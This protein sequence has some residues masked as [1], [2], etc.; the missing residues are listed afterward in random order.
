[1]N[2]QFE[3]TPKQTDFIT[4]TSKF[5][6]FSG[7]YGAGKTIAGCMRGLL[8]SQEPGNFGL[9][10]RNTYPELR[11]TTRRT[12]FEICPAEYYDEK[13]GGQWKPSENLLRLVNG[14]EII[15]RHLDTISE[16]ELK[17]LNLG[18][19]YID[20]A[21]EISE[22]V[23]RVLQSR[24]R[25]ANVS[26]RY[27][28]ITCNPSPG[29]WIYQKFKKP[30]EDGSPDV[31]YSIIEATTYENPYLPPDYIPTLLKDYPEEMIKR[32]IEGRWDAYENAIYPEFDR[33]VH[34]IPP[35]EIPKG[36]E[37]LVSLDHGM[38]N[39]TA[40]LWGAIDFDNNIYIYDEYYS[41]G[42]VSDHA[43]EIIRKT[44]D[45]V[46]SFWL[47]DPS[48]A[49]KTR[50]KDGM[51][52]SILEEYED[53]DLYFT[54]ANNEKLAGIN[55]I[56]EFLKLRDDRRHPITR[57]TPAPRLYIMKNCVN[58]IW[59]F[60]Q[61]QWR[62]YRTMGN[63]SAPEQSVDYND[64]AMDSL[65]MLIMSR[66]PAPQKRPTGLELVLPEERK[67]MNLMSQ[68]LPD[69][70]EG[71]DELGTY[72]KNSSLTDNTTDYGSETI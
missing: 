62:K 68:P 61:Y 3:P 45:Q 22:A 40:C 64:H 39:P 8:L 23:W 16:A 33:Q 54:P 2:S 48:T 41:P 66:F 58:T 46:I 59:E 51:M 38:V 14:S 60:P 50:E 35:F 4:S 7:G 27:G 32:Y 20:Q 49:A 6:C 10:G 12:F 25:L 24:L 36:W 70:F 52:W 13:N 17:S 31:D 44:G 18:W 9:I 19:F 72:Y 67:N 57:Q 26:N 69:N 1:M 29:N 65:R 56:K 34:V 28:F 5:S 71:D 53:N 55:R 30:Q 37:R 21:E 47:I 43:R 63:R 15:F 42:I 11:D